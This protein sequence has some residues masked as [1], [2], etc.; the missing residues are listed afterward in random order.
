MLKEGVISQ[1]QTPTD[2]RL[3]IAVVPKSG[4]R[5]QIR[6]DLSRLNE[7]VCRERLMLP[8]VDYT[9]DQLAGS[10]VFTKL[11]ANSGFWQMPL[12]NN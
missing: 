3:C 1:V 11:D 5:V 12:S 4:G 9:L 2:W 6:V 10:K 7:S 8:S